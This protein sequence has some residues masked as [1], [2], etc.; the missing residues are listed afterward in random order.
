LSKRDGA[1]SIRAI[2]ESGGHPRALVAALAHLG[3]NPPPLTAGEDPIRRFAS[4]FSLNDVSH[5]ACHWDEGRFHHENAAA[6][7]GESTDV[8]VRSLQ[9]G[10]PNAELSRLEM[11]AAVLRPEINDLSDLVARA[12]PFVDADAPAE[13]EALAALRTP[14]AQKVVKALMSELA[15]V[16]DNI[17][18]DFRA[19]VLRVGAALGVKGKALMLPV[20]AALTGRSHG[21]ELTAVARILGTEEMLRRLNRAVRV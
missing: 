8:L 13:S 21:P 17:E 18:Y 9:R 6:W 1:L 4:V 7:R 3:W 15:T 19:V 10:Y 5:S 12:E 14:D 16:D 11:L 20:R 2:R